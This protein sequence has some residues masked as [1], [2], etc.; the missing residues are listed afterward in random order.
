MKQDANSTIFF[1]Q[2]S[3]Q[4]LENIL[5]QSNKVLILALYNCH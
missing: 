1:I 4:Y 2:Y 3:F 5:F